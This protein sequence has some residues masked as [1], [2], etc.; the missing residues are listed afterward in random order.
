MSAHAEAP[1][2]IYVGPGPLPDIECAV[3]AGGCRVVRDPT[4][5]SGVVWV[6]QDPEGLFEVLHEGVEWVQLPDAGVERWLA[7]GVLA[8]GRLVTSARGLYGRQVAEHA[9]GLLLASTRRLV[10]AARTTQWQPEQLR[11]EAA[12]S[13][14]VVVVGAGDIGR[15]L[16]RM[17]SLL[18]CRSIAVNRGG[19]SVPHA[20]LT[21]PAERLNEALSVADV[22][23]LAA[24]ATRQT[25]GMLDAAAFAQMKHGAYVVNV[26][27]G[28]LIVTEDLLAALAS[29][30][31]AGAALDVT[32]PE[33]LPDGHPLWRHPAVLITPHVANPPA[34]KRAGLTRRVE[35]NC[36][37][38]ARRATLEGVIDPALGY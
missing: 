10:V 37:R 32:A 23:V 22:V 14:T 4:D 8:D 25:E 16:L 19:G 31:V 29:G 21:L 38:F 18:G 7:A 24:P 27:R 5:A 13:L 12:A 34:A 35:E 9:L 30:Q 3:L 20:S 28:S 17:L 11:G 33:P 15:E 1:R 6:G 2:S 36:R 26:S